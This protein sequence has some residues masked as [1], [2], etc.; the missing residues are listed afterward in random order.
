MG[1]ITVIKNYALPKLVY[2]LSSLPDPNI[3]TIKRIETIMYDFLWDS[4]PAKIK[5]EILTMDYEKGGL[6]MIDLETFIKF[7]KICWIKRMIESEDNGILKNIYISKL[8]PFG[9]KFLFECNFSENDIHRFMQNNFLKDILAAWCKCIENPVISS[10][11]HEILWNNSN[12]KVEGNTIMYT[13][14][15][16]NGIKYFEDVYDTTA[17]ALYSYGRLSEKYNL[18]E[19]DFL[20][21]LTLIHSI[22][23]AWKTNIKNENVNI[24]KRP[25]IIFFFFFFF[26]FFFSL[27]ILFVI[28]YNHTYI[29]TQLLI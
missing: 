16:S 26:F 21:Y 2:V 10:Y 1:K 11:R 15:F 3:Q 24:P 28:I 13:N 4:K 7:L 17:K 23:N 19:G 12:V 6:K 20:K 25:S 22:P 8:K 27:H 18:P 5:R 9:G 14:W 29:Y